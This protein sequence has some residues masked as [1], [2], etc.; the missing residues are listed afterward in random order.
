MTRKKLLLARKRKVE[1]KRLD[2]AST[3]PPKGKRVSHLP[4]DTLLILRTV[5]RSPKQSR[6]YA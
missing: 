4:V 5:T 6:W 2:R 1:E 3:L